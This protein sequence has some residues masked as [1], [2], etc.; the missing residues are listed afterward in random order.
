MKKTLVVTE[1]LKN[2]WEKS[3]PLRNR[4][5]GVDK[6]GFIHINYGRNDRHQSFQP[7]TLERL[8]NDL[9]CAAVIEHNFHNSID[10]ATLWNDWWAFNE[11]LADLPHMKER[12]QSAKLFF[13]HQ[14]SHC[15]PLNRT[16]QNKEK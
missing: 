16:V 1:K 3:Q 4:I 6:K 9:G 8:K 7:E 11:G 2:Y 5:A 14:A 12:Q 15:Q 10:E 13:A